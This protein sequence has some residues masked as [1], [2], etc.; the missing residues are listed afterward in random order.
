MGDNFAFATV[1]KYYFLRRDVDVV[2]AKRW[3]GACELT[4][5]GE[6]R[7][8]FFEIHSYSPATVKR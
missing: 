6:A 2:G 8:Q 1:L 3:C 7:K 4:E 5:N